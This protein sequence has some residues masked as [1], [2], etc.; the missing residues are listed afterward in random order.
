MSEDSDFFSTTYSWGGL[1]RSV[2]MN[3]CAKKNVFIILSQIDVK[4]YDAVFNELVLPCSIYRAEIKEP[5][6][7]R[8]IF[9]PSK[10]Q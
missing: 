2:K 4:V 6:S 10:K 8:N 3:V 7:W 9:S 1:Q 5:E